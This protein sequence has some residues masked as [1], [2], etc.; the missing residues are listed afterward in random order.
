MSGIGSACETRFAYINSLMYGTMTANS[1]SMTGFPASNV[2]SMNRGNLW[3]TKGNFKIDA[4]NN[5]L[6]VTIGATPYTVTLSSANY[7]G[8]TLAAEIKSK[9]QTATSQ[10]ITCTYLSSYKFHWESVTT[11]FK[12][13]LSNQTA[14]AWNDIGLTGTVDITVNQYDEIDGEIRI[15]THEYVYF[16][17][18]YAM[19]ISFFAL[20]PQRN[21]SNMLTV[22]A[23]IN[24]S[25]SNLNDITTA[26]LSVNVGSGVEGIYYFLETGTPVSY[27]Y[28]WITIVDPANPFG[29]NLVF[30][31]MFLGGYVA[32]PNRTVDANFTIQDVDRALRTESQAGGLYFERYGR[33]KRFSNL[34][35]SNMTRIETTAIQQL[36]FD[37]GKSNNFY[38]TLDSGLFQ[39]DVE[40]FTN[41]GVFE[42][43]PTITAKQANYFDANFEFRS[44]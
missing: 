40:Q 30:S 24:I 42:N 39:N 15:H 8:T 28:V 4:T 20:M 35:F 12:L 19:D 22:G 27:R 34:K 38:L 33:H 21:Y 3:V 9:V 11:N 1:G 16:D 10:T 32:L 44:N 7:T 29:P 18:G 31:Q 43:D 13:V 5:K 26:P 2:I 41:I 17:L 14:A 23:T 25:A 36:Y 37:I 6:Y